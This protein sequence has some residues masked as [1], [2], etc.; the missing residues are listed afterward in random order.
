MFWPGSP[1]YFRDMDKS[2]QSFLDF[3][4]NSI[5]CYRNNF[6]LQLHPLSVSIAYG[7]PGIRFLLFVSQGDFFSGRFI[8]DYD[9]LFFVTQGKKLRRVINPSPRYVRDMEQSIDAAKVNK[10]TIVSYI[11][12]Y[13]F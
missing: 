3:Y 5:V 1:V 2:F 13:T 7:E 4:E 9:E 8:L 6:S 12:Y 10:D 11:F